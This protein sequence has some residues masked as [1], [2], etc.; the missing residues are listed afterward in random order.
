[1]RK[2]RAESRENRKR[3]EEMGPACETCVLRREC[4][5][6]QEGTFCTKWRGRE[7][8]AARTENEGPAEAWARGEESGL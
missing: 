2:E 4:A 8:P 1:M 7:I 5:N 3:I 6:A